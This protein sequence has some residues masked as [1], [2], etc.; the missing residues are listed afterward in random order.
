MQQKHFYACAGAFAVLGPAPSSA[1]LGKQCTRPPAPAA[2]LVPLFFIPA[3]HSLLPAQWLQHVAPHGR[4]AIPSG[5]KAARSR[6][7]Q[8]EDAQRLLAVGIV[9][10]SIVKASIAQWQ[11][12]SLVN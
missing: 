1:K 2:A 4:A 10:L 8:R 6:W 5:T 11:S 7:H 9:L 12:V 3:L